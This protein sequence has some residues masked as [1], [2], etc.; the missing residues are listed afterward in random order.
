[1]K[2]RNLIELKCA[3]KRDGH[4]IPASDDIFFDA[5]EIASLKSLYHEKRDYDEF[6]MDFYE[7]LFKSGH[8]ELVC[9]PRFMELHLDIWP[10]EDEM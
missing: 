8:V 10:T 7:L 5:A 9:A 3:K 6:D 1:M 2:K 4:L